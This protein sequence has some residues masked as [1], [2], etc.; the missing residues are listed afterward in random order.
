MARREIVELT[1]DVDGTKAVETIQF[2]LDG[3]EY[4]ID[5]SKRNA[6]RL[7]SALEGYR[8]AGRRIVGA[9]S[10]KRGKA[11]AHTDKEQVR[12]IREWARRNGYDISDR[13][14]IPAGIVEAYNG[15]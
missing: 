1:D 11:P 8:A 4:E 15:S 6:A 12:A 5:L 9:R 7:R 3:V 10:T 14:R 13:G 2:G